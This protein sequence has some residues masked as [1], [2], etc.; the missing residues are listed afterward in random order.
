MV[1]FRSFLNAPQ[2]PITLCHFQK[3]TISTAIKVALAQIL[4]HEVQTWKTWQEI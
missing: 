3:K 1:A 4:P 2:K